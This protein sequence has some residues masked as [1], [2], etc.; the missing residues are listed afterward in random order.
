[1]TL[2]TDTLDWAVTILASLDRPFTV[3]EPAELTAVLL[4]VADLFRGSLSG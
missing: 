3:E 4:R 1:M 2:H